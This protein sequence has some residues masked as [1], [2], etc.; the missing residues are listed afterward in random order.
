MSKGIIINNQD[1][2]L[3]EINLIKNIE[4]IKIYDLTSYISNDTRTILLPAMIVSYDGGKYLNLSARDKYFDVFIKKVQSVYNEE[5]DRFTIDKKLNPFSTSSIDIDE[6][7][8]RILESGNLSITSNYDEKKSYEYSL[9]YEIDE[10]QTL[11]PIIKYHVK[12]LFDKTNLKINFKSDEISGYKRYYTINAIV[13]GIEDKLIIELHKN[14][15]NSYYVSIRSYNKKFPRVE[16]HINITPDLIMVNTHISE[17]NI[18]YEKEYEF[19]NRPKIT[20]RLFKGEMLLDYAKENIEPTSNEFNNLVNLD[21]D[22]NGTWYRLPWNAYYGIEEKMETVAEDAKVVSRDS[23]YLC[24]NGDSFI[25]HDDYNKKYFK[26]KKAR[27]ITNSMELDRIK[28]VIRGKKLYD[29]IYLIEIY[30]DDKYYYELINATTL[31]EIAK[32][33]MVYLS[34][35]NDVI[36]SGDLYDSNNIK[37]LVLGGKE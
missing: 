36:Y 7:T 15:D 5:K 17:S 12:E 6:N 11:I 35:D 18:I 10:L 31:K 21:N 32:E 14:L 29:D 24:I 26:E 4:S 8:K 1:D 30:Y 34:K 23:K 37:K 16:E 9:L 2:L 20:H 25:I 33:K 13:D 27:V 22:F 19:V 28:R 3:L